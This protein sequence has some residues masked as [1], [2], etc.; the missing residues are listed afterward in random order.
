MEMIADNLI[1]SP[2]LLVRLLVVSDLADERPV[3]RAV[4]ER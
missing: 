4:E 2:D 1:L 3:K